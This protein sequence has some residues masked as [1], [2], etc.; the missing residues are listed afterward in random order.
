MY[1]RNTVKSRDAVKN[2]VVT[3]SQCKIT[4]SYGGAVRFYRWKKI[5][6]RLVNRVDINARAVCTRGPC[7]TKVGVQCLFE[8]IAAEPSLIV[9]EKKRKKEYYFL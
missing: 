7:K 6:E 1:D 5:L 8:L 2:N 4:V 9:I 3:L